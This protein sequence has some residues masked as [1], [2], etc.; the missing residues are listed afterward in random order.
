MSVLS[1]EVIDAL[2]RAT[3]KPEKSNEKI[4]DKKE[5]EYCFRDKLNKHGQFEDEGAPEDEI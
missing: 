5:K 4:S 3:E 1:Q 2:K